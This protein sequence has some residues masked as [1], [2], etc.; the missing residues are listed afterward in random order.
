MPKNPS[1][2]RCAAAC[3]HGQSEKS[4]AAESAQAGATDNAIRARRRELRY[5][6][7]AW[8]G[9]ERKIQLAPRSSGS[10]KT[11]RAPTTQNPISM[12]VEASNGIESGIPGH[13]GRLVP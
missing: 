5:G 1:A 3:L 8:N 11:T 2:A 13:A 4:T 12:I 6:R 10:E 9:V 7:P